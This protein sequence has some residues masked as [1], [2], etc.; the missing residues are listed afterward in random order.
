MV[1]GIGYHA[2][3]DRRSWQHMQDFFAEIFASRK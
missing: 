2:A 3:A 1:G